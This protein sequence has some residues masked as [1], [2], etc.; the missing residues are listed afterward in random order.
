MA[1]V[2]VVH[3]VNRLT[4]PRFFAVRERIGR[5]TNALATDASTTPSEAVIA[6]MT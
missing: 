4:K 6:G 5:L 3:T 1:T 2:I